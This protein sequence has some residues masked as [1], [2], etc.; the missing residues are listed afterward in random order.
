MK[1]LVYVL[2]IA[3][4]FSLSNCISKSANYAP[5]SCLSKEKRKKLIQNIVRYTNKLAPEATHTTKFNSAF[6]WYYDRAVTE[7]KILYCIAGDSS[8]TYQLLISKKARSITPM[9][10]GIALKIKLNQ[11]DSII[12]Y[13]EV[14]RMWK[15]PADTLLLRGKYL[16]ARMINHEDLTIYYSKFQQDRFIEFPD[17]RFIFDIEKRRWRDK[18]LDS[19][20]FN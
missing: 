5:D 18:E 10:E 15:M 8:G 14:F 13:D 1:Y 12:Y 9:E 19:V 2:I 11:N 7:S 20:R 3:S 6:N 4:S 16:F 17:H